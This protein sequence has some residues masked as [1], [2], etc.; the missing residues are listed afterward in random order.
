MQILEFNE[1]TNMPLLTALGY[2]IGIGSM[3]VSFYGTTV[4]GHKKVKRIHNIALGMIAITAALFICVAIFGEEKIQY[5]TL[6]T[7]MEEVEKS[8]YVI[9]DHKKD[10]I[11]LLEK[12]EKEASKNVGSD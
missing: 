3:V 11:Y 9:V 6:V 12:I 4:Y 1:V 5:E 10:D 7:D 2:I 8:G